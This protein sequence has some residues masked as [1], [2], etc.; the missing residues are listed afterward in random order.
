[1]KKYFIASLCKNGLLGGGITVETEGITYHTGKL[2]V[3]KEYRHLPI[4]YKNISALS[5][6]WMFVFPTVRIQ[7]HSGEEYKFIVFRRKKFM[8]ILKENIAGV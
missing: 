1:M 7:M 4:K 2:T 5:T 3:P 6:G 8:E